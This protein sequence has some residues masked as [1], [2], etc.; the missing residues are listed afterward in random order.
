MQPS[1]GFPVLGLLT[2]LVVALPGAK[3]TTATT[4]N[5][6]LPASFHPLSGTGYYTGFESGGL[7][8]EMATTAIEVATGLPDPEAL[9]EVGTGGGVTTPFR[10]SHEFDMG[11][12]IGAHGWHAVR[13]ALTFGFDASG[14]A[15]PLLLEF[16]YFDHGEGS[17]AVD[18]VW[19]STDG[20]SW[21]HVQGTDGLGN[22]GVGWSDFSEGSNAW[23]SLRFDLAA[24]ATTHGLNLAGTFYVAIAEEGSLPFGFLNGVAFD[25]VMLDHSPFN[26]LGNGLAGTHGVPTL[27]GTGTLLAGD[28]LDLALDGALENAT[29]AMIIGSTNL[30]VPVKG[31]TLVPFPELLL[32]GV[33]G[34]TGSIG[35]AGTWPAG[36][37]MQ[38]TFYF[39]CWITDPA[40]IRGFAA[41][42]ALEAVTP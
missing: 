3:A 34:P 26:D 38:S 12:A 21:H 5:F 30:S 15:G 25:D 13:N 4:W 20:T 27:S 7:S 23:G 18:G 17:D 10:G 14:H 32:I 35:Y 24:A 29:T 22:A 39:Q 9:C 28:A 37:P 11:L 40:A 31:G 33:S 42:N 6:N 2:A 1:H 36:I 16:R 8:A 19:L 41:S